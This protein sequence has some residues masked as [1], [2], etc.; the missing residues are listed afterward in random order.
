M[1][2]SDCFHC[3]EALNGTEPWFVEIDGAGHRVCCPGCKAVAEL[4]RDSGLADYYRYRTEPAVRPRD[5]ATGTDPDDAW[6]TFDRPEMLDAVSTPAGEGTRACTILVEGVRCAACSWLI[7]RSLEHL[8]GV[9]EIRVN[10]ATARARLVW[11][12]GVLPLSEALRVL[13]RLGYPPHPVGAGGAELAQR[14]RRGAL[15]RLGVAG[16]DMMQVMMYAVAL[17]VG[18]FQDMDA[19]LETLF[20]WVSLLVATPVALYAGRPFFT[21]AWRDIRSGRPGMDVPVALAVGAA[22]LASV[23]HTLSGQGEVY[24]DSVTMFVFFL[25]LGRFLEMGARHRAGDTHE[26]LAKLLPAAARRRGADGRWATVALRELHPGDVVLVRHGETLPA[27]GR[28]LLAPARLDESMLTGESRPRVRQPGE[29]ALAGSVNLGNP[30]ELEVERSGA[31]TLV[32]AVGRLLDRAQAERPPIAAAADRVARWFVIGVLGAAG[33]TWLVWNAIDPARAF[34]I[35]LAVLVVTCPCALSIATPAAMT[36]ATGFLARRG[37]LVTRAG[38]VEKLARVD[39][40]MFDKTGTLTLGRPRISSVEASGRVGADLALGIAATLEAASEHPIARA[41]ALAAPAGEASD[42]QVSPGLG[43]EGLVDGRRWRLGRPDW[44]AGLSHAGVHAMQGKHTTV[45]LADESGVAAVFR[46]EDALRSGTRRQLQR[47]AELGLA[48]E[49]ASGDACEAVAPIA[50]VLGVADWSGGL[51]PEDKLAIMRTRQHAGETVAMVGDGVNDAPVLAGADVSVAL[52]GGTP[53]AQTSA[54]MVLLGDSLEPLVEG[55][56][57]SRRALRIVRQNLGWAA[58]YN[59]T[60][61]PL[62]AVGL[63]APWMAAI[64]M[65][66]SSLLVVLNALRLSRPTVTAHRAPREVLAEG[67]GA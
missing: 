58:A 36:A 45:C 42:V 28:L 53:L 47:L 9:Q 54:D 24:F 25:T 43:I 7:E 67:A 52:A 27:D 11:D 39:R 60:A 26:A 6:R 66:A 2:R 61:L 50:A 35:T 59:L 48:V 4:I 62:A 1:T 51:T 21:G 32:S 38:A 16:I 12:P 19:G 41:F 5:A 18:A 49:I 15:R 44:A 29:A 17:Y 10:P 55:V 13:S 64:G 23:A 56:A 20:R 8:P 40:V 57:G 31:D 3:G 33:V 14:E 30:F 46:L 22:W 37:L 63:I 65:S 34:E